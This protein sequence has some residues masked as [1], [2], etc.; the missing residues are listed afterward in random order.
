MY[1]KLQWETVAKFRIFFTMMCRTFGYRRSFYQSASY[2][3][4]VFFYKTFL[5]FW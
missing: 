2:V 5:M 3:Y 4:G 1:R